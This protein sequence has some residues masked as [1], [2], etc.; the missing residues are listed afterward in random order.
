MIAGFLHGAISVRDIF[1]T[2]DFYCGLLGFRYLFHLCDDAGNPKT[3]YT[4]LGE[5]QYLEIFLSKECFGCQRRATPETLPYGYH[6][7][8]LTVPD[9]T[10]LEQR[11]AQ[12][13]IFPEYRENAR[14]WV[15]DPDGNLL[16]FVEQ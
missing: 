11:L 4:Q 13:G 7:L 2:L 3:F 15:R 9:L 12:G 1:R 8:S 16:E 10:D 5:N 6:H 14:L